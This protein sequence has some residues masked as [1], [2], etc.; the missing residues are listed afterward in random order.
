MRAV[1]DHAGHFK[2]GN[3]E[4]V[5]WKASRCRLILGPD[6]VYR[7]GEFPGTAQKQTT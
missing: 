7:A 4:G 2:E 6:S 5:G 3:R 1:G